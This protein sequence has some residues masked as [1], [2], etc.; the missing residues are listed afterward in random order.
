MKLFQFILLLHNLNHLFH[1]YI[2][3]Y[4]IPNGLQGVEDENPMHGM[5]LKEF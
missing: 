2:N 5:I 1:H 3:A 4:P